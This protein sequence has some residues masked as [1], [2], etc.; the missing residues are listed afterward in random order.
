MFTVLIYRYDSG[1]VMFDRAVGGFGS[2]EDAMAWAE[3]HEFIPGQDFSIVEV[4]HEE[5]L[6]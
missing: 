5:G 3:R 1:N 2:Q 4:E 6:S